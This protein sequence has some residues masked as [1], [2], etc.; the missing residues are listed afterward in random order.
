M[1]VVGFMDE[2]NDVILG[3][4]LY[5][6]EDEDMRIRAYCVYDK[7]DAVR[8]Y[9][10]EFFDE[11]KNDEYYMEWV[12]YWQFMQDFSEFYFE[13]CFSEAKDV[14]TDS[15]FKN[16]IKTTD[17]IRERFLDYADSRNISTLPDK[18]WDEYIGNAS[19]IFTFEDFKSL[20][21]NEED[22]RQLYISTFMGDIFAIE[23]PDEPIV[24]R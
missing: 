11:I 6:E 17:A 4:Q 1:Y 3:R 22:M 5:W 20:F 16:F 8:H 18:E 21:N 24:V 10:G 12:V 23:V 13:D 19:K 14:L 7:A 2:M 15:C 9:L